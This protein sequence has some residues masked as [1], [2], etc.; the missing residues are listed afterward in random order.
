MGLI[1]E[2]AKVDFTTISIA[3]TAEEEKE[4]S[5]LIKKQKETHGKKQV[6]LPRKRSG[7]VS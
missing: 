1:K 4:F 6:R 5:E 3:W 7:A 2:P